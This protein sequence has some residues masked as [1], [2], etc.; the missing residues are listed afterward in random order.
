MSSDEIT[1]ISSLAHGFVGS[2]LSL[3]CSQ[4][5]TKAVVE[6]EN[7]NKFSITYSHM[8]WALSVVKPSA[9]RE[10][11]IEVPNVSYL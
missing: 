4:A 9:M 2:D 7:Q 5:A 1:E 10:I 3:I 11:L 8:K 6:N